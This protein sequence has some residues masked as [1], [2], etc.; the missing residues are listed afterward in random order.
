MN[1]SFPPLPRSLQARLPLPHG[2]PPRSSTPADYVPNVRRLAPFFDEIELLFFE[3]AG[4]AA[5][6]APIAELAAI[7]AAEGAGLQRP[8]ADRS[9]RHRRPRRRPSA[10]GRWMRCGGPA[11][12]PRRCGRSAYILHVPGGPRGATR[13]GGG[14][15]RCRGS[16]RSPPRSA[17]PARIAARNPG[18]PRSGSARSSPG[19]GVS[20]CLDVGPPAPAGRNPAA[21]CGAARPR[22]HG[23]PPAS[24]PSG[25]RDHLALDRLSEPAAPQASRIALSASCGVVSLEVFSFEALAAS[26]EW[27][28]SA[29]SRPSQFSGGITV[30]GNS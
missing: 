20:V 23:R 14:A 9:S 19:L 24:R 17:D 18:L 6:A 28:A 5:P 12:S 25:G 4:T 10:A 15:R 27:L 13:I 29:L 30:R 8:P 3:S 11:S 7:G 21:R 22:G 2:R 16:P 1:L 26:V